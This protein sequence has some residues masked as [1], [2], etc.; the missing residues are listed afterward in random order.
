MMQGTKQ[1][2]LSDIVFPLQTLAYLYIVHLKK[3]VLTSTVIY[4]P[5]I[6]WEQ[7]IV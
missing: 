5:N 7:I 2:P 4:Y 1:N 6:C 3:K